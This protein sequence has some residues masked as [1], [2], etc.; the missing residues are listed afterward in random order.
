MQKQNSESKELAVKKERFLTPVRSL[1]ANSIRVPH[2]NTNNMVR[3]VFENRNI[4]KDLLRDIHTK[5]ASL[6]NEE[7]EESLELTKTESGAIILKE[8]ENKISSHNSF[9]DFDHRRTKPLNSLEID[10]SFEYR[11]QSKQSLDNDDET[12]EELSRLESFYEKEVE[13]N[14]ERQNK[15]SSTSSKSIKY[16]KS[17]SVSCSEYLIQEQLKN[18][19]STVTKTSAN[20]VKNEIGKKKSP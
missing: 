13:Q 15:H 18:F 16:V 20:G 14:S 9:D 6:N 5:S 3:D 4:L 11:T 10:D 2:A 19:G 12:D 7:E 17:N 8:D 1:S